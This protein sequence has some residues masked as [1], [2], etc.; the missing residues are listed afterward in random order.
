MPIEFLGTTGITWLR[1]ALWL[2]LSAALWSIWYGWLLSHGVRTLYAAVG[3]ELF[4]LAQIILSEMALGLAGVLFAPIL[5]ILNLMIMAVPFLRAVWPNREMLIAHHRGWILTLRNH[6]IPVAV[7]AIAILFFLITFWNAFWGW[8]LPPR[9]WDSL[10]Y[11]LPIMAAFYQA[12]AIIPI[13][14]PSVWVRYYPIDGE[15]LNLWALI[16]VGVDKVIDLAFTPAYLAGTA[17]VY[18]LARHYGAR[19]TF[20][21]FGACLFGFAPGML[22]QQV[23]TLND[24]LFASL[25]AMGLYLAVAFPDT[26]GEKRP[27]FLW[28][29]AIGTA[30]ASGLLVGL[31]LSGAVYACGM[32]VLFL[33]KWFIPRSNAQGIGRGVWI[34]S[35]AASILLMVCLGGYTYLRNW[36]LDGNPLAPFAL[37]VGDT[38]IWPGAKDLRDFVDWSTAPELTNLGDA[39]K[40]VTVWFEP[41]S[42]VYDNNL[43]GLGALWIV[44]GVPALLLWVFRN[45][46]R[47]HMRELA[48]A[49]VL[50]LA[51]F[52]TPVYWLPRYVFP[53]LILGGISIAC[54]LED[55]GS[56]TRRILIWEL[57][58]LASFSVFNVLAPYRLTASTASRFLLRENDI[59]RSSAQFI[60]SANGG[61][62][63]EWVD[64]H[65]RDR[66]ATILVG[67]QVLFPYALYGD[68]LRNT[69]VPFLPH[70]ETDW[71]EEIL[72]VQADIVMV[73]QA[74]PN[75]AWTKKLSAFEQVFQEGDYVVFQRQH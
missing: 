54:I 23:G 32:W 59:S 18:G 30:V 12:H 29:S 55:V 16:L 33:G 52:C 73:A 70:S 62:A 7:L 36:I 61:H 45:I 38:E 69:V 14:S 8:F 11:H 64:D 63:Y 15:L 10:A 49:A 47:R 9:D 71:Q 43:G 35:M 21:V 44:L 50:I 60:L 37:R 57:L 4:S 72:R 31:K 56:W 2:T 6:K 48:L 22:I 26:V 42:T 41:Y 46:Q 66:P 1:I 67:K 40:T 13:P 17:A 3:A 65:T 19:R 5:I 25:V 74:T 34:K 39:A 68:D 53:I 24:A 58:F 51:F 20:A 28:I 27:I 75:Y